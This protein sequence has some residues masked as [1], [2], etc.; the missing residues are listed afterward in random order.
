MSALNKLF[1]VELADRY[2]SEKQLVQ[3]IPKLS[4]LATCKALQ[5]HFQC[6]L[7][8]TEGHVKKL[9]TVFKSFNAKV[10]AKKCETTFGLLKEGEGLAAGFQG[11]PA[12]NAAL[13][14]A[15]QKIEHHAIASYGCLHAWAL[16]LGNKES[17]TVLEEVLKEEKAENDSFIDLAGSCCNKEA[18]GAC[19]DG[20][21]CSEDKNK[22]TPH[23]MAGVPPL[24]TKSPQPELVEH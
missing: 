8:K 10:T 18:L 15:A 19:K 3:A 21:T 6:H 12:I 17:A 23:M 14:S 20:G 11:S 16:L 2:D 4:K 9:E 22:Q 1:L 24:K 13:I 7:K 5:D